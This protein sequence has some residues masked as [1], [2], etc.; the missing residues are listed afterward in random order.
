MVRSCLCSLHGYV[1]FTG[2]WCLL[3]PHPT[4]SIHIA[5]TLPVVSWKLTNLRS[6]RKSSTD[7]GELNIS[8]CL[9]FENTFSLQDTILLSS[10]WE[11]VQKRET[12]RHE[13]CPWNSFWQN[14]QI[15][16]NSKHLDLS[17]LTSTVGII[18][19][20][21]FFLFPRGS[22]TWRITWGCLLKFKF[23]GIFSYPSPLPRAVFLE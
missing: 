20:L 4:C 22:L 13:I 8:I 11:D 19:H 17:F 14:F 12:C 5:H 9:N 16:Q 3:F 10:F 15:I 1:S 23:L 2:V 21:I 7:H 6:L 18:S